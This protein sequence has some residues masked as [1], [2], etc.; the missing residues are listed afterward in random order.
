M[1]SCARDS[2]VVKYC[3]GG[4]EISKDGSFV[5]RLGLR[6]DEML[7]RMKAEGETVL[8]FEQPEKKPKKTKNRASNL[9]AVDEDGQ[10]G[11]KRGAGC[12]ASPPAG[13]AV[14]QGEVGVNGNGEVE[15]NDPG[16]NAV[17]YDGR[18]MTGGVERQ[19]EGFDGGALGIVGEP[20]DEDL[21]PAIAEKPKRSDGGVE[22][23]LV[24][25]LPSCSRSKPVD[26]GSK[27][28]VKAT[29]CPREPTSNDIS[30]SEEGPADRDMGDPQCAACDNGGDLLMCDGPCCRGFHFPCDDH[31]GAECNVLQCP[32][33]MAQE[34]MASREPFECPNCLLKIQRCFSCQTMGKAFGPGSSH[35]K[36]DIIS[37]GKF[38]CRACITKLGEPGK[39]FVC[40]LHKCSKCGR[41][42]LEDFKNP[43]VPCRRCPVAMHLECMPEMLKLL[44][45]ARVWLVKRNEAGKACDDTEVSCDFFYCQNHEF[46]PDADVVPHVQPIFTKEH[47]SKWRAHYSK[48][49][50]YLASSEAARKKQKE[51]GP[52]K[53]K[54]APFMSEE[55]MGTG[56]MRKLDGE[57]MQLSPGSGSGKDFAGPS[58][59]HEVKRK[60]V[61]ISGLLGPKQSYIDKVEEEMFKSKRLISL[62]EVQKKVGVFPPYNTSVKRKLTSEKLELYKDAARRGSINRKEIEKVAQH[63][64]VNLMPLLCE[65]RYTSY[66]RHFTNTCILKDIVTRVIPYLA[67][68]D[69]VVDFSCGS[70]EW[71]EIMRNTCE[72]EKMVIRCKAYDPFTPMHTKDWFRKS[73]MD[74]KREEL[75]NGDHLVI[76][77][78]PPFGVGGYLAQQF[79]EHA[80]KFNPRLLVLIVPACN[81]SP[82]GYTVVQEDYQICADRSFYIPGLKK[83]SWNKEP[84]PFRILRRQD[85]TVA[86]LQ[87]WQERDIGVDPEE[88]NPGE[89]AEADGA[90]NNQ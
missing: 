15:N 25:P 50:P 18:G 31:D 5:R 70:N 33:D 42:D 49:F 71:L 63:M 22:T 6:R 87:Y 83:A 73:W 19:P 28:S 36:C 76:G 1:W 90:V 44:T 37:C 86:R 62:R 84:P 85:P 35:V 56:K 74:V 55:V 57:R 2:F 61:D 51:E 47:L 14:M 39:V 59:Q 68:N 10:G 3:S 4:Y 16:R 32:A 64:K 67:Q 24:A 23:R 60:P 29:S 38:Y 12:V 88:V 45:P 78:N 46:L 65:G 81:P 72:L 9:E 77:L 11:V 7:A 41:G 48:K 21:P 69:M 34:I 27:K 17:S 75:D 30:D 80:L 89:A 58:E 82:P 66:G 13:P 79:V 54:R 52:R 53:L 20:M 43:L 40:P 26:H 8:S